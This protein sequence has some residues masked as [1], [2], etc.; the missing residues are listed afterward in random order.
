MP[1]ESLKLARRINTDLNE[2]KKTHTKNRNAIE[3]NSSP[4]STALLRKPD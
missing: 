2:K 4:Y 3:T 1:L